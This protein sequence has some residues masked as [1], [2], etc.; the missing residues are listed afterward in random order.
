VI[1]FRFRAG[2]KKYF[3]PSKRLV[4]LYSPS[5]T[6]PP[7]RGYTVYKGKGHPRT[8]H[9]GPEREYWYSCTLSLASALDG[10]GPTPRPLY[11]RERPGTRSIGGRVGPRAVL[12][13]C[14]KSRPP[15]GFYP[16]TV[17]PVAIRYTDY[18]ITAHHVYI[19]I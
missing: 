9:E 16:R 1:V 11:T 8:G 7:F 2:R 5:S 14:R 15:P 3:F 12:E 18:A 4:G 10:V 13:G 6:T 19:Y 17:Q